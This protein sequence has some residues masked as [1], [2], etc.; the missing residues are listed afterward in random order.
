[1]P[2]FTINRPE[3][4]PSAAHYQFRLKMSALQIIGGIAFLLSGSLGWSLAF[5][6]WRNGDKD[7][8]LMTALIASIS[9]I[10]S[11]ALGYVAGW[12][13]PGP[14]DRARSGDQELPDG[15][16]D[17]PVSTEEV[18]PQTAGDS[19]DDGNDDSGHNA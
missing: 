2:L 16:P 7:L 9:N 19:N 10:A 18:D 14:N 6:L 1:M 17:D 8:A 5:L 4:K 13:T 3:V 11:A 12:L 15:T